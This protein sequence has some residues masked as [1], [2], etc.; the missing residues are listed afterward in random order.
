MHDVLDCVLVGRS[1]RMAPR[2]KTSTPK[3]ERP[4]VQ[5]KPKKQEKPKKEDAS[6]RIS[7]EFLAEVST[8]CQ[9]PTADVHKVMEAIRKYLLN[10]MKAK[11]SARI[12]NM[13]SFRV[14]CLEAHPAY[15]REIFGVEKEIKAKPARKR[16]ACSPLKC[17]KDD[18]CK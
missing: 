5:Q 8:L 3:T 13:V 17:L 9:I 12:P 10:Q 18:A 6:K 2:T 1:L 14:K 16:I 7:L 15:K 4:Q 11:L